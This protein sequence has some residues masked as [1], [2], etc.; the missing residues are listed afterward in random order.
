MFKKTPVFLC[1]ILLLFS[2]SYS[3]SKKNPPVDIPENLYKKISVD[4][5]NVTLG[6]ALKIVAREADLDISYNNDEIPFR[7][8]VSVSAVNTPAVDILMKILNQ[9]G[10][11]IYFTRNRQLL[12]ISSEIESCSINGIVIDK[13]TG[14][15]LE[16]TII[17]LTGIQKGTF[18]DS[19]GCFNFPNLSPGI[20]TVK[21]IYTGFKKVV[22]SDIVIKKNENKYLYIELEEDIYSMG[23]EIIITADRFFLDKN[24]FPQNI[25][26][27]REDMLSFP[28]IGEDVFRSVSRLP[29][30]T[31][32]DFSSKFNIRGG[33]QDEV[34]VLL[35]GLALYDPFHLKDYGGVLSIVDNEAIRQVNLHKGTFPAE[36]GNK[37]S[38]VFDIES[39]ISSSIDNRYSIGIS[40]INFRML[41]E[42]SFLKNRVKYLLL[43][44]RSYFDYLLPFIDSENKKGKSNPA[45]MDVFGKVQYFLNSAN[46]I[47][48]NILLSD[49]SYH[50][51]IDYEG[52]NDIIDSDYLS[53][54]FWLTWDA[55][56]KSDINFKTI[57]SA[58]QINNKRFGGKFAVGDF[59]DKLM[60]VYAEVNDRQKFDF[61][62][63]KQDWIVQLKK[64]SVLKMG[65]NIKTV[66]ASYDYYSNKNFFTSYRPDTISYSGKWD[67]T[68]SK[69]DISIQGKQVGIYISDRISFLKNYAVE[70]GIRY[71]NATWTNERKISP[72]INIAYNINERTV[73]NAGWGK[74][75]QVQ[76]INS[77][78]V[79]DGDTEFYPSDCSINHNL[80]IEYNSGNGIYGKAELYYNKYDYIRPRY[81]NYRKQI[82][83]FPEIERDR[84]LFS[85]NS[86]D[87]KGIEFFIKKDNG[88]RFKWWFSYCYSIVNEKFDNLSVPKDFDQRHTLFID[89]SYTFKNSWKLSTSWTYHTGW[90]YTDDKVSKFEPYTNTLYKV[91]WVHGS[92]NSRRFPPYH[93]MDIRI[94]KEFKIKDVGISAFLEIINLYNRKNLRAYK[95]DIIVYDIINFNPDNYRIIDYEQYWIKI[96][97]YFGMNMEF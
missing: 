6:F 33:N 21:F 9:T 70:L 89:L 87:S 67:T 8:L 50:R 94:C 53:K 20:Y 96:F 24:I 97:P 61:A 83:L 47:K 52:I 14:N 78:F 34:L 1:L 3:Q 43:G 27:K 12:I 10:T 79:Q 58:G 51:K 62:E 88:K 26:L 49:D 80:S 13:K 91:E 57:M 19:S 2:L 46:L 54:Y 36:Y 42:G 30:I 39:N 72:R 25:Y 28:Q 74:F 38:G 23:E 66:N 31:A 86:G 65:F 37:I 45:Y 41:L 63:V 48:L 15:P 75:Y 92:L 5:K 22:I 77:L 11:G 16:D 17:F 29:G 32:S 55:K 84:I 44:R 93:R 73:L 18:S 40:P 76:D 95:T 71:D 85:P 56:L 7:K 69:S 81:I 82:N 35:D 64:W 60:N 90:P 68:E 59:L 4:L